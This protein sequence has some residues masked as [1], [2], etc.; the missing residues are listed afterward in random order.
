VVLSKHV[1]MARVRFLFWTVGFRSVAVSVCKGNRSL[2]MESLSRAVESD[3]SSVLRSG[4]KSGSTSG[5]ESLEESNKKLLDVYLEK[6]PE[7]C[8]RKFLKNC[9]RRSQSE[10]LHSFLN[11]TQ[12]S[13]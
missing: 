9:K 1:L 13:S 2:I 3:V 8:L 10:A 11:V 12:S 6:C 4:S 7:E 5:S